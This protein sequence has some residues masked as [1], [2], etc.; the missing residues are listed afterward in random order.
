MSPDLATRHPQKTHLHSLWPKSMARPT[1]H[2]VSV[3]GGKDSTVTLGIAIDRVGVDNVRAIY[4]DTCNENPFVYEYLDYLELIF[5]VKID[6]LKA[7]FSKRIIS[8]RKFIANDMR[9]KRDK[10]GRKTR[11][12]NKAKRRALSVLIP[13]GNAFLD[14]CLWKGRFPS[15]KGQFCTEFLKKNL[16][17]AYQSEWVDKGYNVVSWQGLRRDESYNRRNAKKSERLS[18]GI[19]A[20]RPI[21][22]WTVEMVFSYHRTMGIN[23]N[24]LYSMGMTRVGCMPCCNVSK[25]ELREI[26]SRFPEIIARISEW[27]KLVGMSS[28]IGFSTMLGS[29]D[30]RKD[31]RLIFKDLEIFERVKWSK[32]TFGGRQY[33]L[34]SIL[35]QHECS[36]AYGLC[37]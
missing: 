35:E 24:P 14:L 15:R 26:S 17:V 4:C 25:A 6:R 5:G 31:R 11:W 9:T 7:D 22:D 33:S 20:F 37:E 10:K 30:N 29:K 19:Y 1:I 36:S 23:P 16:A 34:F 32:T 27:E 2:V 21:V 12:T 28:K 8:K 3:S 18:S 13:T